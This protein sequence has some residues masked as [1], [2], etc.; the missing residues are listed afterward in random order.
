MRRAL[1]ALVM[2]AVSAVA[3]VAS[4]LTARG[5]GQVRYLTSAVLVDSVRTAA[6]MAPSPWRPA[7]APV[8][9][10]QHRLVAAARQ[11][12]MSLGRLR[13]EWQ[14][15][16]VCEVGGHWAMTGPIYSGIGFLNATWDAYG[17]RQFAPLAG[18][19]SRDEQILVAMKVTGGWVPDQNGCS[20]S[21]W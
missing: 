3:P 16:A 8:D 10:T 9:P 20:P 6:P 19:A 17:G 21:G 15:V 18:L 4:H 14:S 12:G 1:I 2:S 13:Q 7:V 11:V 5:I